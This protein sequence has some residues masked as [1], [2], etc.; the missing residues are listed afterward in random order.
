MALLG[1][2]ARLLRRDLDIGVELLVRS[3]DLR[4]VSL[5]HFDCG[6][7]FF[8]QPVAGRGKAQSG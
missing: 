1:H 3:L 7:V 8:L 4:E 6:E 5:G 2:L